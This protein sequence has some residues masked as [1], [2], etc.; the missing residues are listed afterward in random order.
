MRVNGRW[1]RGTN[2]LTLLSGAFIPSTYLPSRGMKI[3]LRAHSAAFGAS[4]ETLQRAE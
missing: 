3:L 4:A 1:R 2:T